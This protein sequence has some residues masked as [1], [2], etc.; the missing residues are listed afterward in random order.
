MKNN[1]RAVIF[2]LG[3]VLIDFDHFQAA[4]RIS[5]FCDKKEDEIFQM[6]F[7]SPLTVSFGEGKISPLDFFAQVK[8]ALDL[9][10]DYAAF[11][12]IWNEIFFLTEEN[13]KVYHLAKKLREN[14][15]VALLSNVNVLHF[16]FI[17]ERFPILDAFHSII[18]SFEAGVGKPH[19]LIY[20]KALDALA[21]SAGDAFYTDDRAELVEESRKL[22][23]RGFVFTGV[24]QLIK[25]LLA[26]GI[27]IN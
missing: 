4:R 27:N 15:R 19:P 24:E 8:K 7:D 20:R 22:G 13:K 3:R 5:G 10:L 16:E 2:D 6:F 25:D 12:P 17:K 21:V 23:I 26:S 9:K 14:Y 1:I 11:V 18:T